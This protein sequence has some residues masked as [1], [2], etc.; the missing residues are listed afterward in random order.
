ASGLTECPQR[1]TGNRTG[2]YEGEIHRKTGRSGAKLE[3]CELETCKKVGIREATDC[4]NAS[5][6]P[7]S[8]FNFCKKTFG[9]CP[10][11]FH[12]LRF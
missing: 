4:S 8:D 5:A 9:N 3:M 10:T 1:Q 6:G 12:A 11:L 2:L 7:G